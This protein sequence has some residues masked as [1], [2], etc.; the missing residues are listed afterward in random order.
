MD[1]QGEFDQIQTPSERR[2]TT[3]LDAL[4]NAGAKL[5]PIELPKLSTAALRIILGLRRLPPLMI[6]LG[7]AGLT[8]YPVNSGRLAYTFRS[9]RF[10]R[11]RDIRASEPAVADARDGCVDVEGETFLSTRTGKREPS[12]Y[13]PDWASAVCVPC[14]FPRL[15]TI[16][17]VTGGLYD[18]GAPLRVGLAFERVTNWHR[19]AE[20]DCN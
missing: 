2:S 9:S 1:I 7:A 19:S 17:H 5:E 10:I 12:N 6:S 3:A 16:D 8:S 18:E 14:G 20:M 15:A 13:K 11:S 4:R